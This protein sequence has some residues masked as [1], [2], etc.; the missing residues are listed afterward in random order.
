MPFQ[1]IDSPGYMVTA[2]VFVV[3]SLL[4]FF[5]FY[6]NSEEER[7]R[8]EK[9]KG[10]RRKQP[11][12]KDKITKMNEM[13]KQ[14]RNKKRISLGI[15]IV[16]LLCC[17]M[18][19]SFKGMYTKISEGFHPVKKYGQ[20]RAEEKQG[21]LFKVE[22]RVFKSEEE[23][24]EKAVH[25]DWYDD[26]FSEENNGITY[27]QIEVYQTKVNIIHKEP[28]FK[29]DMY[30][31]NELVENIDENIV[32]LQEEEEERLYKIFKAAV[33]VPIRGWDCEKL[34]EAYNAGEELSKKNN[35]SAMVFQT[36]VLAEGAHG[37][38]YEQSRGGANSLQYLAGATKYF[39]E[40]LKFEVRDAGNGTMVSV[41]EVCFREG[42]MDYREGTHLKDTEQKNARHFLVKAYAEFQFVLEDTSVE[43]KKYLTYLYYAGLSCLRI[44]S[45]IEDEKIQSDLC[46]QI[47]EEWDEFSEYH[48][49]N[50]E[51]IT[52]ENVTKDAVDEV[53][54]QLESYIL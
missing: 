54:K 14:T 39:E 44:M 52:V 26:V 6:L 29:K 1:I 28:P 34:W 9:L 27:A 8:K 38:L 30:I 36:A 33:G 32:I 53:R 18:M 5:V 22:E 42:K 3:L 37:N 7:N 31:E 43:D 41:R 23:W 4:S 48:N 47:V 49:G 11:E 19:L 46:Q 10:I 40:F 51:E 25:L 20:F 13:V 15:G 24:A 50:V 45:Y 35:T 2:G 12:K 21:K 16:S 17:V